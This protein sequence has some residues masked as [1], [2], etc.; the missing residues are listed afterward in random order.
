MASQSTKEFKDY[1]ELYR[2][3]LIGD[4]KFTYSYLPTVVSNIKI[5]MYQRKAITVREIA[6]ER[7]YPFISVRCKYDYS[8][9]KIKTKA[10][11]LIERNP[12]LSVIDATA[13][14]LMEVYSKDI[15]AK[16]DIIKRDLLTDYFFRVLENYYE[17]YDVKGMVELLK[18]SYNICS[19]YDS[20]DK[21][22]E[23]VDPILGEWLQSEYD[24]HR[25]QR[26]N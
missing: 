3:D 18:E 12:G 24:R 26:A 21:I 8:Y 10:D 14:V 2:K 22:Q 6:L 23:E 7:C 5:E 13:S 11:R 19:K 17:P 20:F 25:S 16:V 9:G 4:Y 15:L 1:V